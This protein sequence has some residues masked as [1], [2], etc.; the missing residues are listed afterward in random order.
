MD[1]NSASGWPPQL[2][3]RFGIRVP[4][5]QAPMAGASGVAMAAAVAAA[6][7]LGA[8]PCAML[9]PDQLREQVNELAGLS[10]Q[11]LNLN[12]F[13]HEPAPE[14]AERMAAWRTRLSDYYEAWQIPLDTVAP[15][16][17]RSPFDAAMCEVVED[18]KPAVVSFHF[19]LPDTRLLQR[20]QD[21]G[22]QV[23]SSA[24]TVAEAR[25]LEAQGCDVIIAQGVEAG[26]HRGMFLSQDLTTQSGTMAL[27]PQIV[28]AV[29][30]PVIAAGGIADARGILA[31]FALGASAVQLG[32]C[33]LLT[34][35]SLIS[36]LHRQA[37][38]DA[39][40]NHTALTNLFSGR[41][42]R[43]LM[44]RLMVE[45]GPMSTDVSPFP[46]GGAPLAPLKAKAEAAGRADFSSLWSGQNNRGLQTVDAEQLTRHLIEQVEAIWHKRDSDQHH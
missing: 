4:I 19:G 20:V 10:D 23:L 17:A 18:I 5:L 37:L 22:C 21:A 39:E 27:L 13:C 40:H 16:A 33:Y 2:L 8:L 45:L 11:P 35:Q 28:D 31:A 6:G 15:A 43:G 30:V 44:N 34:P 41:P 26:G 1:T 38:T 24:T 3:A 36:P 7:G 9:T 12:F 25:W 46:T 42:A 29:Q 14:N 32:T